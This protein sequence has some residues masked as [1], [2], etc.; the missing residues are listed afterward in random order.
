MWNI[1]VGGLLSGTTICLFDGSPSGSK[2]DPDWSRLWAFAERNGVTWF[3][4]GAAFFTSC[5]KAGLDLA[6]IGNLDGI[7]ALGS[8]GS[9]LPHH[10]QRWGSAQFASL[11]RPDYR[12]C[13]GRSGS[14]RGACWVRVGL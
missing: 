13:N 7:R 14:R 4:A 11:G 5:Q 2:A 10:V 1:Q 6:R 9:P 8:T 3:G 12:W